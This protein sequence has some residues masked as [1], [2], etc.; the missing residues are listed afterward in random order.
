MEIYQRRE[1]ILMNSE[2]SKASELHKRV[3]NLI[4]TYIPIHEVPK[5]G[6]L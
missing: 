6:G 2:N 1:S 3:L 4:D 5:T